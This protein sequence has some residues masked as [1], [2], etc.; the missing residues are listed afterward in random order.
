MHLRVL[1]LLLSAAL[2]LP[3]QANRGYYRS[4]AIHGDTIVFVAEGDLWQ[5][6]V[7]GGV[8]RRLTTHPGEESSPAFS[9]DGKTLAFTANYEGPAE[10]YTIP[11][12]GGLPAR[13]TFEGGSARVIGW[14]P[15]ARILYTTNRY[16]G[17]PGLQLA[18]LDAKNRVQIIPLAQAAQGAYDASGKTLFFT[19]F[20]FQGSHAKRYKGGTAQNL[21][22]FTEGGE[23]VA[24]TASYTGT[25]R[26]AMPWNGRV[27]FIS[28]RDGTMNLWSMDEKGGALRQHTKH[29]G[30]DIK[31][32]SLQGG[33]I[34]YQRGADLWLYDIA[35]NRDQQLDIELAS[36]FD[37]LRER[38]VRNPNEYDAGARLDHDGSR[39]IL[40][41][42]GRV[43]L[44]PA[45]QGRLVEAATA[46][47]SRVRDARMLPDGKTLL[48]LST[49]TGEVELWKM[50]ANGSG[51]GEPLTSGGA[52]LRWE[53][54]PSPDGKWV[55][56]QD[57]E[58][59]LYLLNIETKEQ[60]KVAH[61][62]HGGNSRP[63]FGEVRFSPDS[64]WLSF[65]MTAPNSFSQVFLYNIETSTTTAAT[66][67]RYNSSDASWSADGRFLYFL[68][69]RALRSVV[70]SPWGPR[71]PE[72]FFDKPVKVYEL[73]LKKGLRSPFLPNDELHPGT[74]PA[75]DA[76][77]ESP[78]KDEA[79]PDAK[80]EALRI[81]IDL[82]GLAARIL[83]V[84]VPAGNY[85]SLAA[86][87]KRLCWTILE[88]GERNRVNLQ[89]MDVANKGDKPETLFEDIRA[90]EMSGD[91]KKMLVR[92]QNDF[93]IFDAA[94]REAALKSPKALA[95]AKV[96]L[97]G[98][99]FS[100]IP[101]EEFREL[102]LDA[103]RLHRD[104]F[105]DKGMH[106]VRW[107]AVLDKYQPLVSRVRD[108][109]ELSDLIA[110]MVSE[111]SAL[112]TSVGGG[113]LRRGADQVQIGAL[114]A[115]LDRDESAGGY[116]VQ[117][118]YRHDPDRP[119]RMAPLAHPAAGVGPGDVILAVNGRDTLAAAAIGELLRNTAGRQ[120][121]LKVKPAGSAEAREV[122]VT[123][124]TT[125]A[126][127]DLR[128]HEWEYTRRLAVEE[129]SGGKIGYVHLR[130]M[131]GG[132][133]AQWAEE[134]YPVHDRA[135]LIID[136]R[137]NRGGNIDSWILGR[138]LRKAWFYWQPRVGKP[139]WNMQYAFRGPIVVLQDEFTA[140]DGEAFTEGFKRLG[141]G[142]VI[143]TRTWGGE[144]WL[145][146]SNTLADRGIATAA[147]IGVFSPGG[148][149]L[150]EG[151]GVDPDIVV[152][153][154]PH[155]T[156]TGRDA[157]LEAALKHLDALIRQNPAPVPSTPK[158]PDKSMN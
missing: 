89:C 53:A 109:Q 30:W 58:N 126:E 54:I 143:G 141:L 69:D 119:D 154:L 44:A 9:P 82:D 91:T 85:S 116:V 49:A 28:D 101:A 51:P 6:P 98:W 134:Y 118:V 7:R 113:D 43:F 32:A 132:D 59:D 84:P 130:A 79:K 11:A 64:R 14:T 29:A 111:L 106:G 13:R 55:A 78:A 88:R 36:D 47:A 42:R 138:L 24:L 135:G 57:K 151:H 121:L 140:S 94:A 23:A 76:K 60:R 146:G 157:Q 5:V 20:R 46:Q 22:R 93:F 139:T 48:A 87:G 81:E 142:K 136:V 97:A 77:K 45:R 19:R 41:S 150:I 103:W 133:I 99:T 110:Q 8:A 73:A 137:H 156:F 158:Y 129:A 4:P 62:D 63:S 147:E 108:R 21:W 2:L 123:P 27:Y 117:H 155:A 16:A 35:S 86:P 144:I 115:R 39:L 70:G 145:T 37:H 102:F 83:E 3:A 128:Y 31:T 67:D 112:H 71:A 34:V 10:V 92:K 125:Q 95:E 114:G 40:L 25:S 96:N 127:S 152:D 65:S 61:S 107:R 74:P 90:W 131:G 104:Y 52:V 26:D 120:V 75:A 122:I 124:M 66:S 17:L 149:W 100:I 72:P 50:P 153:N 15:D 80:P 1:F 18:T 56:H 105:Y 38:W 148:E 12:Q 68:S 33:R